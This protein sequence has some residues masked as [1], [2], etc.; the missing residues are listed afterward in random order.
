MKKFLAG[1]GFPISE[2]RE[3]LAIRVGVSDVTDFL[4][5]SNTKIEFSLPPMKAPN[6]I[7]QVVKILVTVNG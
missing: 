6:I 2:N 5:V 3:N 1:T 4:K 7:N